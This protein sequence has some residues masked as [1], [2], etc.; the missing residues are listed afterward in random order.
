V[1]GRRLAQVIAVEQEGRQRAFVAL[2]DLERLAADDP[3]ELSHI[4]AQLRRVFEGWTNR[5]GGVY[6]HKSHG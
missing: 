3:G 6:V 4:L 2:D 5:T 1:E